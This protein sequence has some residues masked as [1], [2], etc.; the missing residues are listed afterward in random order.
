MDL[1]NQRQVRILGVIYNR[2]DVKSGEYNYYNYPQYHLSNG[3]EDTGKK[4]KKKKGSAKAVEVIT[5]ATVV[6]TAAAAD[7]KPE[8]TV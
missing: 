1:L 8:Q 6:E 4:K 7:G 3:D 2:A 5:D